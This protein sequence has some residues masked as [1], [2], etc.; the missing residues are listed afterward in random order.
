MLQSVPNCPTIV[1][2]KLTRFFRARESRFAPCGRGQNRKV[3]H[4]A[5]E[6]FSNARSGTSHTSATS[7]KSPSETLGAKNAKTAAR[8]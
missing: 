5:G 1:S 3:V 7:T 8:A 2:T 6:I 4:S